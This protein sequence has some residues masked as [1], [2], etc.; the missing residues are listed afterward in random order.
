MCLSVCVCVCVCVRAR[1]CVGGQKKGTSWSERKQIDFLSE[2]V[3]FL[4]GGANCLTSDDV[5]LGNVS[6]ASGTD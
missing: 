4:C 2:L 6:L 1:V 3:G 5:V